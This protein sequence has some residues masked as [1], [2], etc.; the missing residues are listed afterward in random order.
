MPEHLERVDHRQ[1]LPCVGRVL[2]LAHRQLARLVSDRVLHPLVIRLREDD[3]HGEATRIGHDLAAALRVVGPQDRGGREAGLESLKARLGLRSPLKRLGRAAQGRQ[4][5]GQ[6]RVLRHEAAVVVGQAD[7]L[8]HVR[9]GGRGGPR[10]H[11]VGLARVHLDTVLGQHVP[12][13]RHLRATELTLAALGVEL[14]PLEDL[15]DLGDIEQVLL[16]RQGEH[17]DVV[18]VNHHTAAQGAGGGADRP[19]PGDPPQPVRCDAEP[20]AE[21][22]IHVPLQYRRGP[23]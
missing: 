18:E 22:A 17:Q 7:E 6:L 10:A 8:P 16:L 5:G 21:D 14:V 9:R 1:H 15:E 13:E 23:L 11:D 3:R 2:A 4:R 19:A 20:R 12:Q